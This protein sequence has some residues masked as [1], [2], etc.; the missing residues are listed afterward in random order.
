MHTKNLAVNDG[1]QGEEIEDLAAGL[2]DAGIAVFL[3]AFFVETIHLSNLARFMVASDERNLIWVSAKR[4]AHKQ[5][6]VRA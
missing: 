6:H 2:P 4:S 5:R 1:G 3:L